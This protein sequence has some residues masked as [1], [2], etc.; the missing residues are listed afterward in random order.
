MSSEL[1]NDRDPT[2]PEE[3]LSVAKQLA[4]DP[5][6]AEIFRQRGLHEALAYPTE[7]RQ[8][9]HR[10][11]QIAPQLA[12]RLCSVDN[13]PVA[14]AL[15]R[16]LYSGDISSDDVALGYLADR[17]RHNPSETSSTRLLESEIKDVMKNLLRS[18]FFKEFEDFKQRKQEVIDADIDP[19][20]KIVG[21][22]LEQQF[23]Y[24]LGGRG[25]TQLQGIVISFM[26]NLWFGNVPD[27]SPG[28]VDRMMRS[29]G[30]FVLF[31]PDELPR[32]E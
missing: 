5:D 14:I 18:S 16:R 6:L 17:M 26:R 23:L 21:F 3:L 2:T 11:H 27:L 10:I 1:D 28:T 22:I 12:T 7:H 8:V 29:P 15:A 25:W 30:D 32:K 4:K 19:Y 20:E 9:N 31:S 24:G 13:V